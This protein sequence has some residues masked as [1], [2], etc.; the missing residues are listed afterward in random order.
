MKTRSIVALVLA[1]VLVTLCGTGAAQTVGA[2]KT[3]RIEITPFVGY[4]FGDTETSRLGQLAVGAASSYGV[5][6]DVRVRPDAT[7]QVVYDR[8]DT[9]LDF[10]DNDPF[11]P[12]QIS[13]DLSI[14]YFHLGGTV[15]LGGSD[16]FQ[17]Y[18]GMTVGATRFH[19]KV[20][21]VHDEWRFSLGVGV[22]FK[23]ALSNRFGVRAD[24]RLWPTFLRTSGGLFCSQ[25]GGCLVSV[26]ADFFTQ[27]NATVG[28]FVTF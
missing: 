15:E 13:V 7:V 11:L 24:A 17:P 20:E 2:G 25:P 6:L 4:Q 10:R 14:E 18:F 12:K 1:P 28:L 8:Q 22:G 26:E 23:T 19:P 21:A 16:R 27:A 3:R 5:M 9:V